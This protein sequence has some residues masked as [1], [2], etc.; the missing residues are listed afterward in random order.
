MSKRGS[1]GFGMEEGEGDPGGGGQRRDIA[2]EEGDG[3]K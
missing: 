2:R 3:I 1:T